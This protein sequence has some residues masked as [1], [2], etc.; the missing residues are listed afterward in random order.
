MLYKIISFSGT[1]DVTP[2]TIK[3]VCKTVAITA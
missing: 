1:I 2:D 3:E